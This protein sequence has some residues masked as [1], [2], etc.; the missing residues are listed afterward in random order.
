MWR[1]ICKRVEYACKITNTVNQDQ[2]AVQQS[3]LGLQCLPS[4]FQTNK[5][6]EEKLFLFLAQDSVPMFLLAVVYLN[7]IMKRLYSLL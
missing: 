2:T 3:D 7:L 6:H 4:I 5:N 1:L